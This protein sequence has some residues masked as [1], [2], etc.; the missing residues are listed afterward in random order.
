MLRRTL[1]RLG[2]AR[3]DTAFAPT[4]H[5]VSFARNVIHVSFCAVPSITLVDHRLVSC[6]I[7]GLLPSRYSKF[8]IPSFFSSFLSFFLNFLLRSTD[9]GFGQRN[10]RETRNES[11]GMSVRCVGAR[12][13]MPGARR[14][15]VP[16]GERGARCETAPD[17]DSINASVPR[18]TVHTN[19]QRR[20]PLL[21]LTSRKKE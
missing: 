8:A 13:K 17:I 4:G 2:S 1:S 7:R 5:H 21:L 16:L 6:R 15:Y 14:R 20:V 12:W 11:G 3:P 18:C 10:A 19:P 9:R